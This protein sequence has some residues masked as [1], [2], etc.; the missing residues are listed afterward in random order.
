LLKPPLT[1]AYLIGWRKSEVFALT[2]NQVDLDEGTARLEVGTTKNKKGRLVYLPEAMKEVIESQWQEH[3]AKYPGRPLVFHRNGQ[4]IKDF[5]GSWQRACRE[6]GLTGKI[7]HD[8]RRTAI[9]NMVRAGIPERVAME[10]AGH[11]TRAVFDR[12]IIV[13]PTDLREAATRLEQTFRSLNGHKF[14]HNRPSAQSVPALS[15]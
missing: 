13:S 8:F 12:Y 1:F 14:S 5:R 11:K 4:P 2:W 10:I 3:L 15:S 6:A 9:R 7:P